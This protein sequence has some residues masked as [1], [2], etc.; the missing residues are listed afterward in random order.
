MR[1][2]TPSLQTSKVTIN[3]NSKW[4]KEC[5]VIVTAPTSRASR[6]S[7]LSQSLSF[8]CFSSSA[9]SAHFHRPPLSTHHASLS[10]TTRNT[11]TPRLNHHPA[12]TVNPL[13][14]IPS[15]NANHHSIPPSLNANVDVAP[16]DTN[17]LKYQPQRAISID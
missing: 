4:C 15:S 3:R 9:P 5:D 6:L 7:A 17:Q 8:P 10:S 14:G 11:S 1:L 2:N 16:I 13:Q 12:P